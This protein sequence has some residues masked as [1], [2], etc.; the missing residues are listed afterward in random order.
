MLYG[1]RAQRV[2]AVVCC[3]CVSVAMT[4]ACTGA[5]LSWQVQHPLSLTHSS[6]VAALRML[7]N[8]SPTC[9]APITDHSCLIPK[10]PTFHGYHSLHSGASDGRLVIRETGCIARRAVNTLCQ[11]AQNNYVCLSVCLSVCMQYQVK[12]KNVVKS[13]LPPHLY[14]LADSAYQQMM[15]THRDQCFVIRFVVGMRR[16]KEAENVKH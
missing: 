8:A 14:A 1:C 10:T 16:V 5:C 4:N 6:H 2:N 12:Y 9:M 11:P 15:A 7:Q 3:T 13:Q